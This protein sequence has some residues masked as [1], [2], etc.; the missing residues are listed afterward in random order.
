MSTTAANWIKQRLPSDASFTKNGVTLT[1]DQAVTAALTDNSDN[2]YDALADLLETLDA[3]FKAKRER[4][5]TGEVEDPL[6]LDRAMYWRQFGVTRSTPGMFV[7][8][9]ARYESQSTDE[10]SRD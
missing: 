7:S 2:K 6:L 1:V 3:E 8:V 9:P 4:V 5:G 10:Y